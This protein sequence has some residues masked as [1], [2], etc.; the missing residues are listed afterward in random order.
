MA[1]EI[2]D[3]D[4][5]TDA[6]KPH[7]ASHDAE[8]KESDKPEHPAQ[9]AKDAPASP[10]AAAA[11]PAAGE[12]RAVFA[13]SRHAQHTD[14]LVAKEKLPECA[15]V[16]P[17]AASQ[18]VV[19]TLQRR[20][21]ERI[22]LLTA[23]PDR[24]TIDKDPQK[25][26]K[27]FAEKLDARRNAIKAE[28]GD[29]TKPP[30]WGPASQAA[31]QEYAKY[32][33]HRVPQ[34][35]GNLAS[36]GLPIPPGSP[37]PLKMEDGKPISVEQ[38]INRVVAGDLRADL[39]FAHCGLPSFEQAQKLIDA[40]NWSNKW[41]K[42]SQDVRN[43]RTDQEITQYINERKLPQAWLYHE[44]Q[45]KDQWRLAASNM[46]ALVDRVGSTTEVIDKLKLPVNAP[47]GS[48]L[49]KQSDGQSNVQLDLP[50][51]LRLGDP[52]NAAKI[53]R[54]VTWLDNA[55]KKV[56]QAMEQDNKP[57]HAAFAW[58]DTPV[59]NF[60]DPETGQQI[61]AQA[62]LNQKGEL[63][64]VFNP[65]KD[66]LNP[67]ETAVD[68]NQ[69]E[70][71]L[72]ARKDANGDI[73]VNQFTQAQSAPFYAWYWSSAMS[74]NV[75]KPANLGEQH[76]KPD[77][78]VKVQTGRGSEYMLA[79]NLPGFAATAEIKYH[80][81]NALS[82]VMDLSMLV[83]GIGEL[84]MAGHAGYAAAR[85]AE[86][87]MSSIAKV[88]ARGAFDTAL[89]ASGALSSSPFWQETDERRQFSR[90]RGDI[91]LIGAGRSVLD[92]VRG[93]PRLGAAGT[94]LAQFSS[95]TQQV[96]NLWAQ[97]A[98]MYSQVPMVGEIGAGMVQDI[99]TVLNPPDFAG[100]LN[101]KIEYERT[102][103]ISGMPKDVPEIKVPVNGDPGGK[104]V[105]EY[106]KLFA[107][108]ASREGG[109]QAANKQLKELLDKARTLTGPEASEKDREAFKKQLAANLVPL[110][111]Y[112]MSTL[113][114]MNGGKPLTAQDV[115]NI[116]APNPAI[117]P[118]NE[119]MVKYAQRYAM[120]D[121]DEN[122][123]LASSIALMYLSQAT[124]QGAK[125]E[126]VATAD[127]KVHGSGGAFGVKYV[128]SHNLA[129]NF[130]REDLAAR[131]TKALEKKEDDGRA[132][133]ISDLMYKSGVITPQ[134]FGAVLQNVISNPNATSQ[135]KMSALFSPNGPRL[136]AIAAAIGFQE[137]FLEN[138]ANVSQEDY[139]AAKAQAFGT[140]SHDLENT[141]KQAALTD[142]D[143]AIRTAAAATIHGLNRLVS[144]TPQ[145]VKH[146]DELAAASQA[147]ISGHNPTY[148][149]DVRAR[150][151]D[152][153]N[154]APS[155]DAQRILDASSALALVAK[156]D[157]QEAPKIMTDVSNSLARA[158]NASTDAKSLDLLHAMTPDVVNNLATNS[159]KVLQ[160][161]RDRAIA[162][163][164]APTT[165]SSALEK[166]LNR[167]VADMPPLLSGADD[168][169]RHN[170]YK[171]ARA[172]LTESDGSYNDLRS[173][174]L[175]SIA[176]MGIT[177]AVK[178]GTLEKVARDDEYG[179]T[180]VA[181]LTAF[182]RLD[183]A[184][185]HSVV[186]ELIA[187]ERDPGVRIALDSIALEKAG[188]A[189]QQE[190]IVLLDRF[191]A[192]INERYQAATRFT[193]DSMKQFIAANAPLLDPTTYNAAIMKASKREFDASGVQSQGDRISED[194]YMQFKRL[195]AVAQ[196]DAGNPITQQ[197]RE[198]LF[199]V[200]T[201][202]PGAV[203][204][205]EKGLY[206]RDDIIVTDYMSGM[207]TTM[208]TIYTDKRRD[209][210]NEA[211]QALADTAKVGGSG[212][213]LSAALLYRALR[214]PNVK[215]RPRDITFSAWREM[216]KPYKGL[217]A[218]PQTF[219][220][221]AQAE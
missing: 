206:V 145:G 202:A 33:E 110:D 27:E 214:N 171:R 181:A 192:A 93:A 35:I 136:P 3:K 193:P 22:A 186:D 100:G 47:P 220:R 103:G 178:D 79:K 163:M 159:P 184:K 17:D 101:A 162:T 107:L 199:N 137:R 56:D 149:A 58:G 198:Y 155:G 179:S 116:V 215:G 170:F 142:R 140:N 38:Y 24:E 105:E 191:S 132:L 44:G 68:I 67:G 94:E 185:L 9:K 166:S 187:K 213:D 90:L 203:S 160:E 76:F 60:K 221:V 204:N 135:E 146:L 138:N 12:H 78:I 195:L 89:G 54:L 36:A 31:F 117:T 109:D 6:E 133:A 176:D 85:G 15:I 18:G 7:G 83:P 125:G 51:D 180:R 216:N 11:T 102:R 158:F 177:D 161:V 65:Q 20:M 52:A 99:K 167:L 34:A 126:P 72:S 151:M 88:G 114:R 208:P 189:A 150:L 13:P 175:K 212:R 32:V 82:A 147:Y 168:A 4:K 71:R 73:V 10:L 63:I 165:Y 98:M 219:T 127:A 139:L 183:Q 130:T 42:A 182:N 129:V 75:G 80:G 112:A 62:R 106:E 74:T 28:M 45:D 19:S 190:Q 196:G 148:I 128:P 26:Q 156:S 200:V 77:D 1:G 66:K 205:N 153:M 119:R 59:P 197:A 120:R 211:A 49:T 95:P 121:R 5:R 23:P 217:S 16:H 21:L 201:Q 113:E 154:K 218:L 96:A 123:E 69:L 39:K 173:T 108:S 25:A 61:S 164:L 53:E 104:S 97:R 122:L 188:K 57:V 131:L 92:A 157:Q 55:S 87:A 144:D 91:F 84:S 169:T 207:T 111:E 124:G 37:I 46:I 81:A 50:K 43:A 143:P 41:D 8:K 29:G 172:I 14:A 30:V 210:I 115:S 2:G 70:Q 134:Q 141:L 64:G 86:I 174:T 118:Q 209:W 152:D 194:R 48:V 40:E